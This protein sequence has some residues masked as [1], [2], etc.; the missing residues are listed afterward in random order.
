MKYSK[1]IEEI[2]TK[3]QCRAGTV[4]RLR[5]HIAGPKKTG[6]EAISIKDSTIGE[7]LLTKDDIKKSTVKFCASYL[8]GNKPNK[9]LQAIENQQKIYQW[10]MIE[11]EREDT[12]EVEYDDFILVIEKFVK[13]QAKTYDF[14]ILSGEKNQEAIFKL[15]KRIIDQEDVPDTFRQTTL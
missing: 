5:E 10:N 8:R 7:L 1:R 9:T 14:L 2:K 3:Y 11:D 13:K 15:F 6:R 4:F 12:L